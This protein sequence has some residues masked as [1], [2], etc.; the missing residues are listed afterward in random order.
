MLYITVE[1]ILII[2]I[3]E[4]IDGMILTIIFVR[5]IIILA[6]NILTVII[7]KMKISMILT[8]TR[9]DG[10]LICKMRQIDKKLVYLFA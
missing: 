5:I 8:V 6:I 7:I 1:S 3:M 9:Q 2:R 10:R 4:G